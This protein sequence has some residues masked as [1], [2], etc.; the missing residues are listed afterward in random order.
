L[1][2]RHA[3]RRSKNIQYSLFSAKT[4]LNTV[5]TIK[6]KRIQLRAL[7]FSKEGG[8]MKFSVKSKSRL[9]FLTLSMVIG[10]SVSTVNAIADD[11]NVTPTNGVFIEPT[12]GY[13][14]LDTPKFTYGTTT[15][16]GGN[17]LDFKTSAANFM[18]GVTVGANF[19]NSFLPK[20]FG[21]TATAEVCIAHISTNRSTDVMNVPSAFYWGINGNGLI[22][23]F[24][25]IFPLETDTSFAK[26]VHFSANNEVTSV[27]AQYIGHN[28]L[29]NYGSQT[30]VNEPSVGVY[31]RHLKQDDSLST[32]LFSTGNPGPTD[33]PFPL[34][35]NENIGTNYY[36]VQLGDTLRS[37][38]NPQIGTFV[39]GNVA[40]GGL[41]AHL[42]GTQMLQ[43]PINFLPMTSIN[44]A[45]SS[46]DN[47]W[48]FEAGMAVG[49]Q[50]T[51]PTASPVK[52]TLS[53]GANWVS[54]VPKIVNPGS[55][56]GTAAH[57]TTTS[58]VNPY[59]QAGVTFTLPF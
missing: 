37:Q 59:V 40:V 10:V 57:L 50:W 28:D 26:T 55:G 22:V 42:N 35:L 38:W 1:F 54:A 51:P 12:V 23:P 24:Q 29:G 46:S 3:L 34:S 11:S 49:I 31:Y 39:Q 33:I 17:A 43:L 30:L 5:L 56:N 32:N 25:P 2:N 15:L 58:A 52:F 14:N 48:D 27:N 19:N 44:Q 4:V 53:G 16:Q 36:G 21:S 18:P 47:N 20:V 45:V 6:I 9:L 7:K 8:S 13:L 41:N